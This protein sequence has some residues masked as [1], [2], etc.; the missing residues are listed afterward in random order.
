MESIDALMAGESA[1]FNSTPNSNIINDAST[2]LSNQNSH[3]TL[4]MSGQTTNQC[5]DSSNS[6]NV[7]NNDQYWLRQSIVSNSS[8]NPNKD[9]SNK[10]D[11]EV[12]TRIIPHLV[13]CCS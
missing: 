7:T 3:L 11:K 1:E 10:Q 12:T 9:R 2:M 4:R 13:N 5:H 8:D 6:N